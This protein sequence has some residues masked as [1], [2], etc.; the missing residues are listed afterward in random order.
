MVNAWNLTSDARGKKKGSKTCSYIDVQLINYCALEAWFSC[1]YFVRPNMA[2]YY[3]EK[4]L[5]YKDTNKLSSDNH[6][7]KAR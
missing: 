2:E 4:A 7:A 3:G 6:K 5:F 1:A